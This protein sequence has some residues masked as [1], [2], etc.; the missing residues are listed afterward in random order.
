MFVPRSFLL[1]VF[2]AVG[3]SVVLVLWYYFVYTPLSRTLALGPVDLEIG[4]GF[5]EDSDPSFPKPL[6]VIRRDLACPRQQTT[7]KGEQELNSEPQNSDNTQYQV[8]KYIAASPRPN[9]FAVTMLRCRGL[10]LGAVTNLT[11]SFGF[12]SRVGLGKQVEI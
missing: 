2:Y 8:R 12:G 1:G 6:G 7:G 5:R 10:Y 11:P 9:H 3:I 4:G